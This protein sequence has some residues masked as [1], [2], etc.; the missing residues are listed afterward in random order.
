M[1]QFFKENKKNKYLGNLKL[2]HITNFIRKSTQEWL[3][4]YS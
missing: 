1:Q 4:S 3:E 2:F